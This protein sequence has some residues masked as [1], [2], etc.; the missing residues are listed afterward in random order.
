MSTWFV[1]SVLVIKTQGGSCLQKGAK[2]NEVNSL[3]GSSGTGAEVGLSCRSYT[4]PQCTTAWPLYPPLLLYVSYSNEHVPSFQHQLCY[5]QHSL[6][7][8]KSGCRSYLHHPV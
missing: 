5:F 1:P 4:Y 6:R 3:P 2:S 8:F 7:G